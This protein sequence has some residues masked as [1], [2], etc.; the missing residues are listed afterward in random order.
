MNLLTVFDDTPARQICELRHCQTINEVKRATIYWRAIEAVD[1]PAPEGVA[2]AL[3][4]LAHVNSR[5]H[6]KGFI[7][8][9][10]ANSPKKPR[11]VHINENRFLA[12]LRSES[13]DEFLA[14]A[15]VGVRIINT[16]DKCIDVA[17][18]VYCCRRRAEEAEWGGSGRDEFR[19]EVAELF[20]RNQP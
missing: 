13:W 12:F 3:A 1:W 10:A 15:M 19:L 6:N 7:E 5:E 9:W 14:S 2:T 18:M 4:L 20:Y 17:A 11:S 8:R 16:Y